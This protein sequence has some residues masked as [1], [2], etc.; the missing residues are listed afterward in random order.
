[1]ETVLT[2]DRRKPGG[3]LHA[4]ETWYLRENEG[5]SSGLVSTAG[6]FVRVRC[7]PISG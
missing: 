5:S 7:N 4:D 1:M 6:H 3:F 2:I